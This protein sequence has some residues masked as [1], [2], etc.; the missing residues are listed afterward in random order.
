MRVAA[1]YLLI[2]LMTPANTYYIP[3]AINAKKNKGSNLDNLSCTIYSLENNLM[4]MSSTRYIN[5]HSTVNI[6]KLN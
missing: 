5:R 3:S 6:M 4:K 1:F 2:P